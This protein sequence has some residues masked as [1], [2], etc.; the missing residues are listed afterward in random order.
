M[1][2]RFGLGWGAT[3]SLRKMRKG[4]SRNL[5]L[6]MRLRVSLNSGPCL[7]DDQSQQLRFPLPAKSSWT[8]RV[9]FRVRCGDG[10]CHCLPDVGK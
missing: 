1:A 5:L 2:R 10:I 4:G 6:E 8:S 7:V 9:R 3:G